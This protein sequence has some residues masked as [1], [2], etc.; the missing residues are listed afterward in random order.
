MKKFTKFLLEKDKYINDA[1][2]LI[3][4][5]SQRAIFIHDKK[6]IVGVVSEG[7]ILKAFINKKNLLTPVNKI[8]NKSFKFLVKKYLKIAKKYFIDFSILILPVVNKK[9]ELKD[10]ITLKD[11]FKK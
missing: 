8:M 3:A 10:V 7:D 5:N 2:E 11:V 1:V 9:M 4:L 6:K